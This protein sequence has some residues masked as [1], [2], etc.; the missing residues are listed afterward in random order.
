MVTHVWT[1]A[2]GRVTSAAGRE[3]E[4]LMTTTPSDDA[5]VAGIIDFRGETTTIVDLSALLGRANA[6][7]TDGGQSNGRIVVCDSDAVGTESATGWLASDLYEV[8]TVTDETGEITNFV[9]VNGDI[10]ERAEHRWERDSLRQADRMD[11]S[12]P[13]PFDSLKRPF[14]GQRQTH[15]RGEY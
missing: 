15:R 8:T 4:C 5:H 13:D 10:T 14:Q 3:G 12:Q 7:R 9:A 1:E 11:R 6:V 2:A